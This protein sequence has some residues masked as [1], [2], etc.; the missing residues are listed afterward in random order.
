MTDSNLGEPLIN[1]RITDITDIIAK[2]PTFLNIYLLLV[3]LLDSL[4]ILLDY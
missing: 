2:Y 1:I 3:T 4:L